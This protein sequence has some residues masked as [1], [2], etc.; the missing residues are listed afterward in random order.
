MKRPLQ[1]LV[2]K[3]L[4]TDAVFSSSSF[5]CETVCFRRG[6]NEIFALC[7]VTQRRL[8]VTDVSGQ[9]IGPSFKG[10]AVKEKVF[11]GVD[12][13]LPIYAA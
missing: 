13:Q 7:D 1:G 8:V 10:K 4:K 12:N 3:H 9:P 11:L 2:Y 6:V 5:L